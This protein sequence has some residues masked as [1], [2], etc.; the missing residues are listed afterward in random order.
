MANE[1]QTIRDQTETLK[2]KYDFSE[3]AS[4]S[5]AVAPGT[6][7][8]ARVA[9]HSLHVKDIFIYN[10]AG[11]AAVITF[12]DED[13]NIKLVIS[14]GT[15]ETA[16]PDLKSSLVFGEHD[17]YARTDQAVNAEITVAGRERILGV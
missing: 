8:K 9:D 14:V 4:V 17:I 6:I 16:N 12:Y 5:N 11:V 15:L 3:H 10:A 1:A 2:G 13:S 7:I